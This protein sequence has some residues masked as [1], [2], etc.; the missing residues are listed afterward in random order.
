MV[1]AT[2]SFVV[3]GRG[4]GGGATTGVTGSWRAAGDGGGG[5]AFGF[6]TGFPVVVVA[7][8]LMAAGGDEPLST[9]VIAGEGAGAGGALSTP[10]AVVSPAS[11]EPGT[12]GRAAASGPSREGNIGDAGDGGTVIGSPRPFFSPAT[13]VSG[14]LSTPVSWF[15]RPVASRPSFC[16]AKDGK[17]GLR[18]GT[19]NDGGGTGD[20][21]ATRL[22]AAGATGAAGAGRISSVFVAGST[23][24][25]PA[26]T[27]APESD[28]GL[29]GFAGA[30][31]GFA[32]GFSGVEPGRSA[33]SFTSRGRPI[34]FM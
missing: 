28:V 5:G 6:A 17:S 15:S 22:G 8:I 2:R 24:I 14:C 29:P 7:G 11:S 31:A 16:F 27:N 33:S 1:E 25:F 20:T 9:A 26:G 30:S 23:T 32:A 34:R 21:L 18:G 13:F 3:S 12:S 10:G 4:G 19:G